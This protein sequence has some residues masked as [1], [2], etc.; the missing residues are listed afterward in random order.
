MSQLVVDA[1][2][3]ALLERVK[4]ATDLVDESGRKLGRFT[5]EPLIPWEPDVTR[6]EIDRRVRESRGRTLA[7]IWKRLGAS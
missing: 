4:E 5:P 7:D 1:Q 2:T 3:R 6:E